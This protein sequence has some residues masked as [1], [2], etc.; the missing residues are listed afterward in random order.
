MKHGIAAIDSLKK[1]LKTVDEMCEDGSLEPY[2]IT[3]LALLLTLV[4]LSSIATRLFKKAESYAHSEGGSS[5]PRSPQLVGSSVSEVGE[6][7]AIGDLLRELVEQQTQLVAVLKALKKPAM[8]SAPEDSSPELPRRAGSPVADSQSASGSTATSSAAAPPPGLDAHSEDEE[9]RDGIDRLLRRLD[10]RADVVRAD[11][12]I[13]G[14]PL[15]PRTSFAV[16]APGPTPF[17][18]IRSLIQK[19]TVDN[20]AAILENFKRYQDLPPGTWRA[21][22]SASPPGAWAACAPAGGRRLSR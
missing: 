16:R 2:L 18:Q 10:E 22:R 5:P 6:G 8:V 11:P 13:A 12:A 9:L 3:A 1:G 14:G 20:R 17:A 15:P 7:A 21:R 4:A 19:E